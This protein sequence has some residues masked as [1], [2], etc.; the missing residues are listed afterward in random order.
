MAWGSSPVVSASQSLG[1]N[2]GTG[3]AIDTTGADTIFLSIGTIN[4]TT[5]AVS[6]SKSNTWTLV[7]E[8][9]NGSGL[10][11]YLYR[12]N[13]AA[14]VG[15]GHTFTVTDTS[16]KVTISLTA[17]V[18]GATSSIDDQNNA[19]GS[20]FSQTLQPGSITPSQNNTLIVTGIMSSDDSREPTT[21]NSSFTVASSY[22][23]TNGVS[24]NSGIAYLVQATAAAIN[25][26]WTLANGTATH[27]A[28]TIASFKAAAAA[29][30]VDPQMWL[31]RPI[32]LAG[33][34]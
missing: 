32:W 17:F 11:N 1:T 26:T 13:T 19:A 7:K 31:T 14:S 22:S 34:R 8:I 4:T 18:G 28:A 21:I 33:G 2:G 25:P 27:E 3:A 23:S 24:V 5:P 16:G 20:I 9:D 30:A 15:T 6:D 12:T 29:A 10:K